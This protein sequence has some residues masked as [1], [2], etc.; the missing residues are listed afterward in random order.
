MVM[1]LGG[2]IRKQWRNKR[3][4]KKVKCVETE[5]KSDERNCEAEKYGDND[6][7]GK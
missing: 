7:L 6:G 3:W 4:E 5:V 1:E 2:D